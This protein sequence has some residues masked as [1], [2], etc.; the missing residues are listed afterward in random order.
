MGHQAHFSSDID[1]HVEPGTQYAGLI[2]RGILFCAA[3]SSLF[4][5]GRRQSTRIRLLYRSPC[6][7]NQDAS[8]KRLVQTLCRPLIGWW[9]FWSLNLTGRL[10]DELI[11]RNPDDDITPYI[12]TQLSSQSLRKLVKA[13]NT[14]SSVRI[15]LLPWFGR[16]LIQ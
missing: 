2:F 1:E 3:N 4:C 13:M 16:T 11:D 7:Q 12:C 10:D 9:V 5:L 6:I 15:V 8:G 14:A